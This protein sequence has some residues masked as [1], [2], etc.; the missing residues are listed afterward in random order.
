MHSSQSFDFQDAHILKQLLMLLG[1]EL[2]PVESVKQHVVV[3][4][5][6]ATGTSAPLGADADKQLNRR[7]VVRPDGNGGLG[8]VFSGKAKGFK[9]IGIRLGG[10]QSLRHCF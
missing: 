2:H 10:V 4:A 6:H 9:L 5:G 3:Q 1:V 7:L 8:K